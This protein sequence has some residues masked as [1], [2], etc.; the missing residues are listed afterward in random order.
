M[1]A[2]FDMKNVWNLHIAPILDPANARAS[3]HPIDPIPAIS[4]AVDRWATSVWVDAARWFT[5]DESNPG[6]E[7]LNRRRTGA[8]IDP[9]MQA[10]MEMTCRAL[11]LQSVRLYILFYKLTIRKVN[12]FANVVL[13][14]NPSTN[15]FPLTNGKPGL[16]PKVV[17]RKQWT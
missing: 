5:I 1:S 13:M 8:V 9:D 6:R 14:M 4:A 11:A 10:A 3:R 16:T 15:R 7:L 2:R 12:L 17:C